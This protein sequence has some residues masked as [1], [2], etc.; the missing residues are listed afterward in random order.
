MGLFDKIKRV[1]GSPA[2]KEA[3]TDSKK[4]ND[5]IWE[6]W[7]KAKETSKTLDWNI[8]IVARPDWIKLIIISLNTK[9]KLNGKLRSSIAFWIGKK[10]TWD[11]AGEY[12]PLDN[13]HAQLISKEHADIV[14]HLYDKIIKELA[15]KEF[16]EWFWIDSWEKMVIRWWRLINEKP[17]P[18]DEAYVLYLPPKV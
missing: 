11:K 16:W 13:N 17:K 8:S 7:S 10:L 1:T 4:I 18:D 5:Q 15:T 6:T 14:K 12:K 2:T 9:V 3:P